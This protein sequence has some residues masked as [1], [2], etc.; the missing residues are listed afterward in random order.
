MFVGS[1]LGDGQSVESRTF[2]REQ[3][4]IEPQALL[5]IAENLAARIVKYWQSH[6]QNSGH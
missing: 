1:H 6:G 5:D 2:S 4:R 3:Y